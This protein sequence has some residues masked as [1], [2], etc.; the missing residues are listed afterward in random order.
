MRTGA[1][2]GIAGQK[3]SESDLPVPTPIAIGGR[4]HTICPS[5]RSYSAADLGRRGKEFKDLLKVRLVLNSGSSASV[6]T[7]TGSS[8]A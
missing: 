3:S 2:T 5:A 1:T 7:P 8:F 6:K 4:A